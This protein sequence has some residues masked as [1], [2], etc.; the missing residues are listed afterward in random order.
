[1]KLFALLLATGLL[2]ACES[3][4]T[5]S[6]DKD[7]LSAPVADSK[8]SKEERNKKTLTDL[9]DAMEKLDS[10]KMMEFMADDVVE[11]GDGSMNAVKSK[12]SVKVAISYWMGALESFD[13]DKVKMV[14]EGDDVWVYGTFTTKFKDNLMGMPTKGKTVKMDDIDML[15]FNDAGKITSH[16]SVQSMYTFFGELGVPPPPK[17]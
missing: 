7:S 16:R 12:D 9:Y 10:N 15:T 14:A 8:D 5:T 4:T 13:I 1:M 3:T 11:Y 2:V 17:K 6:T